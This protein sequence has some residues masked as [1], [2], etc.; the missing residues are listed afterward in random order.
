M[1]GISTFLAFSQSAQA[2]GA[3]LAAAA[4]VAAGLALI[5][6]PWL[7]RL[8]REL[9]EERLERIRSQ[10]RA[11]LAAHLHD[12]VLQTLTL[13]QRRADDPEAVVRLARRQER[14]LRAWLYGRGRRRARA[15]RLGH[16]ARPAAEVEDS[17]G[18]PSRW[19]PSA[20]APS[21]SCRGARGRRA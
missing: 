1:T 7:R 19:S 20:T 21:T 18:V 2:A 11:E 5:F 13:I 16:R 15:S 3:G 8:G 12:S 9:A 6:L 17:H 14:E 10:E 4:V